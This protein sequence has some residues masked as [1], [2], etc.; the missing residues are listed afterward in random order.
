MR[1]L[2]AVIAVSCF[3]LAG[4]LTVA[5]S[6]PKTLSDFQP[7]ANTY[8]VSPDE[9]EVMLREQYDFYVFKLVNRTGKC[10]GIALANG[11]TRYYQRLDDIGCDPDVDHVSLT[12]SEIDGY[13][14]INFY[15]QTVN[16]GRMTVHQ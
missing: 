15:H 14:T 11:K 1:K 8:P 3:S 9:Q 12:P 16:T 6:R 13:I 2:L 7:V 4:G 5:D 10:L